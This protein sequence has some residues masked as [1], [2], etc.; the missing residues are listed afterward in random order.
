MPITVQQLKRMTKDARLL[1]AMAADNEIDPARLSSIESLSREEIK[2]LQINAE[3]WMRNY[4][5]FDA[6]YPSQLEY[7]VN[8][9]HIHGIRGLYMV[10]V[11]EEEALFFNT[12]REA[13]SYANQAIKT[14]YID[15]D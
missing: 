7:E 11:I 14:F 5:S 6:Y 1:A 8:P 13:V 9:I 15:L 10:K 12:K 2:D 3:Y 4:A